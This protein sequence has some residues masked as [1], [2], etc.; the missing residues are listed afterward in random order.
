MKEAMVL[1]SAKLIAVDS[2]SRTII[3]KLDSE[4]ISCLEDSPYVLVNII[5]VSTVDGVNTISNMLDQQ[6]PSKRTILMCL[7]STININGL[8]GIDSCLYFS[9][10][11]DTYGQ[12][13]SFLC[14]YRMTVEIHGL[15]SFDFN[16]F[17]SLI[18]GVNLISIQSYEYD[19]NISEAIHKLRDIKRQEEDKYLITFTVEQYVSEKFQEEL[20]SVKEFMDT[21]PDSSTLYWSF[22]ESSEQHITLFTSISI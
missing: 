7:E 21:F 11:L 8:T 10:T 2:K 20:L 17:F 9:N 3:E 16:D 19:N 13:K 15:I 5:L 22:N 12:L 18:K 1:E 6:K 4:N 14:N